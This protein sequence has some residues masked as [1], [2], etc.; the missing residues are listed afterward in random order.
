MR[1]CTL[2]SS[3]LL[4]LAA[5]GGGPEARA[6]DNAGSNT[7]ARVWTAPGVARAINVHGSMVG[8]F[9]P[10][11]DILFQSIPKPLGMAVY[12]EFDQFDMILFDTSKASH[13]E[14]L[15]GMR[16]YCGRLG[17]PFRQPAQGVM[18]TMGGR[19]PAWGWAS[20]HCSG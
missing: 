3:L 5:C 18:D 7:A 15:A 14:V 4:A 9:K 2:I 12:G 1:K 20:G 10:G 16:A 6:I 17:R 13:A 8:D 11:A 19:A